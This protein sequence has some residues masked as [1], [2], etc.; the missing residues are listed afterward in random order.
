MVAKFDRL[1]RSLRDAKDIVDELTAKHVKLSIVTRWRCVPST[2]R[3]RTPA[4]SMRQV[5]PSLIS[6]LPTDPFPDPRPRITGS[7]L[8]GPVSARIET[9]TGRRSR[10]D[11]NPASIEADDVAELQLPPATVIN[12]A[13]HGHIAV[14]DG[15]FHVSSGV[16]EPGELQELPEANDFTADRD[17]V[18]R[19]R[20]RHPRMLVDEDPA[21]EPIAVRHP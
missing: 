20:V 18:D 1:A 21:P 17:I 3:M 5:A 8:G 10:A 19:S 2:G 16:E 11:A 9:L 14:D 12:F 7:A 4:Q 13:I 6:G 15:R